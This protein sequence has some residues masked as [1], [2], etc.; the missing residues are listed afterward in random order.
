MAEEKYRAAMTAVPSVLDGANVVW[1]WRAELEDLSTEKKEEFEFPGMFKSSAEALQAGTASLRAL[2]R[3]YDDVAVYQVDLY[4]P[5]PEPEP[6]VEETKE[7]E[8]PEEPQPEPEKAE[9]ESPA[10]EAAAE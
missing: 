7:E 4:A 6:E 3:A 2:V 1:G 9:A 10:P 5:E 8:T